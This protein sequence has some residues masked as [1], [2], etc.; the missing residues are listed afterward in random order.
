MVILTDPKTQRWAG[1]WWGDENQAV[2]ARFPGMPNRDS[3]GDDT[4]ER[5]LLIITAFFEKQIPLN[6][7]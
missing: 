6:Q 7:N 4:S 1:S 2:C 5:F 3:L